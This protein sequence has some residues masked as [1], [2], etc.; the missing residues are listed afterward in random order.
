MSNMSLSISYSRAARR[1]RAA[2]FV[3][4]FGLVAA[5]ASSVG[6][7]VCSAYWSN[8]GGI[9]SPSAF[10]RVGV[11]E[12]PAGPSLFATGRW[13]LPGGSQPNQAGFVGRWD[14]HV[15]L[16]ANDGLPATVSQ[17]NEFYSIDVGEGP[18]LF[19]TGYMNGN[20]GWIRR[21]DDNRWVEP[22]TV[23]WSAAALPRV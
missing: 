2:R 3:T 7:Q 13:T 21:W 20:V 10:D 4:A 5:M 12:G 8:V 9:I 15:W 16:P 17:T 18:Q 14:G 11:W 6:A 22:S 23:M 19:L 1:W